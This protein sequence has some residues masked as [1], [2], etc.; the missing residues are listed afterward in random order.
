MMQAPAK[1][2]E[3]RQ[4]S[5]ELVPFIETRAL[6]CRWIEGAAGPGA[7]CCGAPTNGGSWCPFHREIVFERRVR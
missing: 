2:E 4:Q 7:L 3:P 1:P 5:R 6:E